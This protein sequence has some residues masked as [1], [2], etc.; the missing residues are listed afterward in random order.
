M[1]SC[2][3]GLYM[4]GEGIVSFDGAKIRFWGKLRYEIWRHYN[5]LLTKNRQETKKSPCDS[6]TVETIRYVL[7]K[8][9]PAIITVSYPVR[10]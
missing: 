6:P 9:N 7:I 5:P 2:R 8:G 3:I 1:G 4:M 10:Q